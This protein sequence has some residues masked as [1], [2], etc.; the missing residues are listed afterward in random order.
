MILAGLL[1]VLANFTQYATRLL[2]KLE[3]VSVSK[4]VLWMTFH[5]GARTNWQN[6][7]CSAQLLLLYYFLLFSLHG[8]PSY[9]LYTFWIFQAYLVLGVHLRQHIIVRF[10]QN[11]HFRS[12]R[13]KIINK[14]NI[15]FNILVESSPLAS[16]LEANQTQRPQISEDST[17]Y[18]TKKPVARIP[19]R[20]F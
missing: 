17:N 18:E 7:V 14:A 6:C 10:C 3:Y 13:A 4:L 16:S 5:S 1:S 8:Y 12:Q 20:Y 19:R 2:L 9:P 15:K 11:Y